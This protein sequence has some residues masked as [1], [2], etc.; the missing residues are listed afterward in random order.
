[1]IDAFKFLVIAVDSEQMT[2]SVNNLKD[3]A[4]RQIHLS[5]DLFSRQTVMD[6]HRQDLC[7][8]DF[9]A[10]MDNAWDLHV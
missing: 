10:A 1:V 9:V 2:I 4:F 3:T 5:S 6:V 7:V 8:T